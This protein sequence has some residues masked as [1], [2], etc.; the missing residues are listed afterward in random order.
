MLHNLSAK[1][2]VLGPAE[3]DMLGRVYE[4]TLPTEAS[5]GDCNDH[6]VNI[7]HL[8]KSLGIKVEQELIVAVRR[9]RS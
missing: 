4:A 9:L 1:Y 8:Y 5:A 3:L 7:L 6:V 2:G